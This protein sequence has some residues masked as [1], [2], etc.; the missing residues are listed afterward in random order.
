[1]QNE[2]QTAIQ[3][4]ERSL[5]GAI[6]INSSDG[7]TD[8]IEHTRKTIKPDNFFF[9]SHRLIFIAMTKCDEPPHIVNVVTKLNEL[10]Y[11]KDGIIREMDLCIAYCP[12]SL[13]YEHYCDCL[14]KLRAK[15]VDNSGTYSGFEL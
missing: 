6:L 12:C 9:D 11:L 8:A 2:H 15:Q 3:L 10:G 4:A 5:I 13:D 1:M 14:I 7:A